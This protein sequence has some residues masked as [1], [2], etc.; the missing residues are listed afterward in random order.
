MTQ[1]PKSAP[2]LQFVV[3]KEWSPW[4]LFGC[5]IGLGLEIFS[6]EINAKVK[7]DIQLSYW[8]VCD[9]NKS[10]VPINGEEDFT[11]IGMIIIEKEIGG[12]EKMAENQGPFWSLNFF[13][14]KKNLIMKMNDTMG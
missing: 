9:Y 6:R 12:I 8:K 1:K 14:K 11:H 4:I 3:S 7:N 5:V 2:F 13:K 10:R